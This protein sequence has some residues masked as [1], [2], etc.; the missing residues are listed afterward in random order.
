MLVLIERG[1]LKNVNK[2]KECYSSYI[3]YVIFISKR[4]CYT[5]VFK[6][7]KSL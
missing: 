7:F 4:K 2:V 1:I 6:Y 5:K 3:K